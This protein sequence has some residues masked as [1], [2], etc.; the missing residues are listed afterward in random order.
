MRGAL[1]LLCLA[2]CDAGGVLQPDLEKAFASTFANLVA[3]QESR[4][5][6]PRVEAGSLRA[7]AS[8]HH[9]GAGA[10]NRGSGS[11]KCAVLWHTPRGE[12]LHD[13]YDVS[14]TPDGCYTANVDG[15]HLGGPTLPATDGGTVTNLL[16]VLDG[17]FETR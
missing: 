11:W 8:C 5:G 14:V 3:L 15:S 2:A 7:S 10:A 13:N 12:P 9:V 6:V 17:C 1:L 16:Y 4:M